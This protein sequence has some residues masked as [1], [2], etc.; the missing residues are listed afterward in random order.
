M[1]QGAGWAVRATAPVVVGALAHIGPAA[2]WL[3]ELRRR[4]FPALAGQGRSGHVALTF[5]DGPD[6]LSTP[7]ILDVLDALGVRAT[8]F[9]LGENVARRPAVAGE[10]VRRGHELAV[11]GWSHDRP[12]LPTPV[13]DVREVLRAAQVVG[14]AAGQAP[15]WYR[16]PYGILTT[17]RWSAARRAGLRPVLW[18]AWGKDWRADATPESVRAT[19][20]AALR[21]GGTVLL[22]DTDHASAPGSWRA[23]LGALP[24]I[25]R[26]CREAGLEVGPLGEHGVPGRGSDPSGGTSACPGPPGAGSSGGAEA[27]A[28]AAR[29]SG[30]WEGPGGAGP[31]TSGVRPFRRSAPGQ[32]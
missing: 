27:A 22:H 5:D 2:T 32:S 25:V 1:R 18:T 29:A 8:F 30:R 3:P 24:G 7:R 4:R 23:T 12:W 14:E 28:A 20:A 10:T 19:V 26:D 16:P 31:V 15:R 6:P 9:F 21:G 13:R 11:H 17:G